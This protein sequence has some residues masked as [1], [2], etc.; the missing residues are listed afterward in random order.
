[1]KLADDMLEANVWM[2]LY[3]AELIDNSKHGVSLDVKTAWAQYENISFSTD[4]HG[5]KAHCMQDIANASL[6]EQ[7][8]REKQEGESDDSFWK[9]KKPKN[10]RQL[11]EFFKQEVG[12]PEPVAIEDDND[13]YYDYSQDMTSSDS[14]DSNK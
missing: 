9:G 11:R 3:A 13:L 1:M 4:P 12:E 6:Q 14:C 2:H 10:L 8:K 7:K 5:A